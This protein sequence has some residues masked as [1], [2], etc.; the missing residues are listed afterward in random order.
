MALPEDLDRTPKDLP[1]P[2]ADE[3]QA[4]W[5]ARLREDQLQ[6]WTKG[7]PLPVAAYVRVFPELARN[8][9]GLLDL[10]AHEMQLRREAGEQPTATEYIQA[11]PALADELEKQFALDASLADLQPTGDFLASEPP[12]PGNPA[13]AGDDPEGPSEPPV[14]PPSAAPECRRVSGSSGASAAGASVMCGWLAT[15]K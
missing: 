10:I 11:M 2:L 7:K 14:D 4:E 3:P 13:D 5:I 8:Q 1:A 12:L 15:W 9:E 6:R